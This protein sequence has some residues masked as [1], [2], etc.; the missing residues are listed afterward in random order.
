MSQLSKYQPREAFF[1]YVILIC[2]LAEIYV[3]FVR[4][5]DA[6]W[7]ACNS[8][9]DR[10]V[11]ETGSENNRRRSDRPA[12]TKSSPLLRQHVAL[13]TNHPFRVSLFHEIDT[14]AASSNF[15]PASPTA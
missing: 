7:R 13:R 9:D 12:R 11:P 10:L 8:W 14:A 4:H 5:T 6:R 15:G 3:P 2:E 1:A